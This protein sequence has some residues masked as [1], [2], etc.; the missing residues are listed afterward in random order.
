MAL[1]RQWV[2]GGGRAE[3]S[4]LVESGRRGAGSSPALS[5]WAVASRPHPQ[6]GV[7]FLSLPLFPDEE[8]DREVKALALG[9]TVKGSTRAGPQG[10]VTAMAQ[11]WETGVPGVSQLQ[12]GRLLDTEGT[13]LQEGLGV[14]G[15]GVS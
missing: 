2:V 14:G 8:S 6:D 5:C 4:G 12:V 13:R 7:L 15:P 3:F 11:A 10:C 9:H 1:E